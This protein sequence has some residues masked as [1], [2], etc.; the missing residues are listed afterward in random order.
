V[1]VGDLDGTHMLRSFQQATTL[2]EI[3]QRKNPEEMFTYFDKDRSGFIDFQEFR[4]ML[5]LL[6]SQMTDAKALR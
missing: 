3:L 5:P 4:E 1:P 6:G 2:E